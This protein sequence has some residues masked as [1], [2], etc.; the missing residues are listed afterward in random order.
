MI[1]ADKISPVPSKNAK[2]IGDA[3]GVISVVTKN[4]IERFNGISLKDILG[5]AEKRYH[6]YFRRNC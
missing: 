1:K 6:M 2:G 3:A 4:E 5:P